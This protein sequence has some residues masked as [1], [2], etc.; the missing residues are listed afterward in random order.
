MEVGI[1]ISASTNTEKRRESVQN[2]SA[3]VKKGGAEKSKRKRRPF[4]NL[5]FLLLVTL[6]TGSQFF[7]ILISSDVFCH[8]TY[9]SLDGTQSL[10]YSMAPRRPF[11]N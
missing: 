7:F 9:L 5:F 3:P 10:H 6:S 4:P 1:L 11:L 2:L 8:Q